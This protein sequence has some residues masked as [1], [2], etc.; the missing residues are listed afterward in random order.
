[1][2]YERLKKAR[3]NLNL[4]QEYV[5]NFLGIPRSAVAQMENGKR[6]VS[7]DE[8]HALCILYG[9]SA[10][11]VLGTIPSISQEEVFT[12]RFDSLPDSDKEEILHLIEYKIQTKRAKMAGNSDT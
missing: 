6:K 3:E 7:S 1:M 8:L 5:A 10:D 4:T 12:R 2:H 9:L 11:F